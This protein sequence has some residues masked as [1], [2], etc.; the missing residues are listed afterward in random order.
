MDTSSSVSRASVERSKPLSLRSDPDSYAVA[1]AK[2]DEAKG[3]MAPAEPTQLVAELAAC[4][5]LVAPS[6]MTADDRTEWIKVARMTIGDIPAGPFHSAC[7]KARKTCRFASEI[8]PTIVRE[9]EEQTGWLRSILAHANEAVER[10]GQ[11]ALPKP[12]RVT[13]DEIKQ[14]LAEVAAE[15][16]SPA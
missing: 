15:R 4:L 9:A 12:D 14:I 2:L 13:P 7:K 6:G 11:Q 16:K 10:Y 5:T 8:V 1:I 3:K